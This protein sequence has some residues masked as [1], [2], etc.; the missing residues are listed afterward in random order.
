MENNDTPETVSTPAV[1]PPESASTLKKP[2]K[3]SPKPEPKRKAAPK[4]AAISPARNP[5]GHFVPAKPEPKGPT[6]E[7]I[8]GNL[9]RF[10]GLEG[11]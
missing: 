9:R 6:V 5:A 7:T 10:L 3:A 2:L 8:T 1:A 11:D 4:P